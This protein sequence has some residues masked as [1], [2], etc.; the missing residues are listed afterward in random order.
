MIQG[1]QEWLNARLGKVTGSRMKDVMAKG[2]G[3]SESA[4]RT[5]YMMELLAYRLTGYAPPSYKNDAM[6]WGNDNEPFARSE[7]EIRNGVFVKEVGLIEH[8]SIAMFAASPDGLV[9]DD[10]LIE[11]KCPNTATHIDFLRTGKPKT[12]YIHQM[13]AQM[14]C[15]GR[16]WVDFV[17]YDPRMPDTICY[18]QI[19]IY[20]DDAVIVAMEEEVK[21]F[22]AELDSL[23]E[24][25]NNWSE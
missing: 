10:G 12:E 21:K 7:Y 24:E 9:G 18:K 13:N 5:N 14:A 15:T 2:K 4:T 6:Q 11:I 1:S 8:P 20:R 25:L 3:G 17:S 16:K 23:E 19:R 22:L